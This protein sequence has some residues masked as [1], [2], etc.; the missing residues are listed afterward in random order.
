MTE[1]YDGG[2]FTYNELDNGITYLEES[3]DGVTVLC[4]DFKKEKFLLL[5]ERCAS[6]LSLKPV[7]CSL[8]GSID[9]GENPDETALR[10]VAE[11]AGVVMLAEN[12][13]S[14]STLHT[15]KACTKKT[16]VYF[17]DITNCAFV[18]PVGDGSEIEEEA[19]V[20]WH[21]KEDLL[22]SMDTLLLANYALAL[23][24]IL[25]LKQDF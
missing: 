25:N 16:Y 22:A 14:L 20:R 19:Y 3:K 2:W 8:T 13:Y 21:S 23:P 5:H 1:L 7:L 24:L 9:E 17:A 10:E 4:Y 15:Y 6:T 18:R 12:M 11:E